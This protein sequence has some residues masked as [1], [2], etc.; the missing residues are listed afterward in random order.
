ML[1]YHHLDGDFYAL[2]DI[3]ILTMLY[4][5]KC[6]L[7]TLNSEEKLPGEIPRW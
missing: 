2:R 1:E 5:R 4:V 3:T 7:R 6:L